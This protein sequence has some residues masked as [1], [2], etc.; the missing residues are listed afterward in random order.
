MVSFAL[1]DAFDRL[2]DRGRWFDIFIETTLALL[3]HR[4]SKAFLGH[5]QSWGI[6][7]YYSLSA[8]IA[9]F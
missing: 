5:S 2:R 1:F 4:I 8:R 9:V 7:T 3:T 6:S